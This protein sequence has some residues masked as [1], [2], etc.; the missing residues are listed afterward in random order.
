MMCSNTP[1]FRLAVFVSVIFLALFWF[2][3]SDMNTKEQRNKQIVAE[4]FKVLEEA[5]YDQ[6]DRYIA[7]N[8]VRHCQATP[9]AVVNSIDDFIALLQV[10]DKSFTDIENKSDVL[11]AEG[12]L[13]AFYGS[14][15]GTHTGQMGPFPPTGKRM[16]SEFAGYHRLANNKIVE[17]WVTWDNMIMLQQ[18]GLFPPPEEDVDSK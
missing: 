15:S 2:S 9:D 7:Q 3:C 14:F 8:Y 5:K 16:Y 4:A 6:L 1:F 11:I 13:V 10:W 17:T 12:D 18:L